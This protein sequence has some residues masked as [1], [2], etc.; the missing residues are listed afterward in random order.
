[1]LIR[2]AKEIVKQWVREEAS[3]TPGF[4]GA[5]FHGSINWLTNDTPLSSTSDVDVL[6][7]LSAAA[8]AEKLGK[9]LY[10]NL[11]IEAS[12]LPVDQ[13]RTAE[14]VLGVSHLAGSLRGNSIISDP[15]GH[16][17][18]IQA[19][20]SK[21][22]AKR[23][24]V[25]RRCEHAEGK[26]RAHLQSIAEKAP[27]HDQV[28]AWLFGTGVTTHILLAAG[29]RNP[30]VRKRYLAVR[31]LLAEYGR[32]DFYE[33][34]MNLLGCAQMTQAE[35]ETHLESLVG[36]FESASSVIRTPF[37]FAADISQL[38]RPVA[39]DGSRELIER[40]DHR[41]AVFWLAVTYTRCMIVLAQDGLPG[42]FEQ[43]E[44]GWHRL[45]ADLGIHS[46]ADLGIRSRQVLETLPKI[47]A[48]AEAMIDANPEID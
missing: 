16:L 35:A 38:A 4:L 24:W 13:I 15:T 27:F 12:Y 34:L 7:V 20:V 14:Q 19:E 26:L 45:L 18:A 42:L 44:P 23:V 47:W 5:F 39:I 36:V 11:M 37:S 21:N 28:I 3:H 10:Q 30:T 43:H 6:I 40:G 8:P 25:L 1:M 46:P 17:H 48:V 2:E 31:D 9:N 41:E 33:T 22:Y 32:L 29:L